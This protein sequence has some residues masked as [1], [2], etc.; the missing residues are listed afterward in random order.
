MFCTG[1]APGGRVHVAFSPDGIRWSKLI[2]TKISTPLFQ[3][4][5]AAIPTGRGEEIGPTSLSTRNLLRHITWGIPSGQAVARE[6]NVDQLAAGDLAD[7]GAVSAPMATRTPLWLYVLRE[8]EVV[9]DGLH[10]GPVGGRIVAEVLIGLLQM[11]DESFLAA[12]PQWT[13]TLPAREG[14]ESFGMADLLTV[15]GVSPDHR[16]Q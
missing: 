7:F 5:M 10:L 12:E 16:G 4:P 3:L 15:A 13:P 2:D 1:R 8:A 11:D 14:S 6:M 9:E